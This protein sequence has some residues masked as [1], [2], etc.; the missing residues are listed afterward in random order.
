MSKCCI[1]VGASH[2]AAQLAVSLRQEGWEGRILVIGEEPV[3]P[4]HRPPLSKEYLA[5][6]KTLEEITIRPREAYEQAQVEFLLQRRVEGI[7]PGYKR[8]TLDDGG[9]VVYDKLCLTV[10]SRVRTVDL[11][12]VDLEGVCY[13]RNLHDVEQIREHVRAGA[14][15][16]IVGGGYIGLEAAAVLNGLGMKVT[17]LEML[18]RVMQRVTAPE[19]SEFYARVH[20]EEGVDIRC[21]TAV[22]AFEGKSRVERV[23]CTDGSCFEADLVVIGVGIVPNVELA[24]DAGLKTD[25]GIVVDETTRTSDPDIH[26]AG[27]CTLHYNPIYRRMLRLESVQN[28]TDQARVAAAA[29]CGL[30][31]KY[32]ALPWFWSD[33]YDLKLQIAGLSQGYDEI[34]VR[35]DREGCRSFAVFYFREGKVIA[36]DAVNKPAEFMMGKRLITDRM[37]VDRKVLADEGVH[38]RELLKLKR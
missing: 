11:P 18:E 17:V 12:G 2:A 34:V 23:R 10:G 28:A 25:N 24:G 7:E 4:Y 6:N 3:I 22:S 5:G 33:Q 16:V 19:V 27:D 9:T 32:N 31:K 13:L 8:L 36:V 38:M 15:A 26:A 1:V 14:G 29:V 20:R 35:G 37:D 21:G 30:D